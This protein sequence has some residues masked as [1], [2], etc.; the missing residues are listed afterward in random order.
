MEN[1]R[2]L[3][4]VD[5][6][7]LMRTMLSQFFNNHNFEV[8]VAAGSDG[9]LEMIEDHAIQIMIVDLK[10]LRES[11][12]DLCKA[13]KHRFPITVRIAMTGYPSAYELQEAR[14]AGFDD[15]FRKPLNLETLLQRVEN[16]TLQVERWLSRI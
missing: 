3:L 11:G 12:I 8:F 15:Y 1:I 10:L 6:E 4:I 14:E 13:I 5:D 7:E 2:K 9:V 16:A